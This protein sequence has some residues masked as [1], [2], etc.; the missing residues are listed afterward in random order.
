MAGE[1]ILVVDDEPVNLKLADILLRREGFKIHTA[2]DGEEAQRVLR[3]FVPDIILADIKLPGIDGL[4]LT[5]RVKQDFRT[6]AVPVIILTAF[7]AKGDRERA[8][9]AGCD[10]YISKPIDTVTLARRIREF[11]D[12]KTDP[13]AADPPPPARTPARTLYGGLDLSNLELES[14]RRR[15]LEEGM[16][17]SRQLLMDLNTRFDVRKTAALVHKWIGAAGVLGYHDIGICSRMVEDLLSAA[18]PDM[19]AIREDLSALVMAFGDPR[20]AALGPI[21]E[22]VIAALRGK[23][24]AMAGFAAEEAERLCAV[25]ERLGVRPRLFAADEPPGSESIRLCQAVMVH[26]REEN[27]GAA[28]L[29]PKREIANAEVLVFAGSREH[30]MAL[31]PTVQVRAREFLIDGWQP[32]EALMRLSFA[33]SRDA[34]RE[35]EALSPTVP[36]PAPKR[37]VLADQRRIL[38]ADDDGN[39]RAILKRTLSG[40][41]F[42]CRT[43]T[44]GSEALLMMEQCLPN[45]VVLDVNMPDMNGFEVLTA[46]RERNIPV[47]VVM[48][49]ARQHEHDVVQSFNLGADDYMSKPFRSLELVVRLNRLL[50]S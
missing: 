38:V 20:E 29:D 40:H 1:S 48:L 19:E 7:A 41:N 35:P 28:W 3:N 34:T 10:G 45:A 24:I 4:E 43:A 17:Q 15:F 18:T 27:M 49:T 32:E 30:I 14:I 11:L 31:C 22:S 13:V 12:R 39:M 5:R 26:V 33:L 25:F 47:R 44:S 21:P 42:D 6:R 2:P 9:A 50:Q 46:I 23:R 16:L 36:W 8:A 37:A